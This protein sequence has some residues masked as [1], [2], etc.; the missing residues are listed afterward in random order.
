MLTDAMIQEAGDRYRREYDRYTKLAEFV[1][2][3]CQ[4]IVFRKLTIRASVQ[5][6]AKNPD[7][8]VEKLKK[9]ERRG[10]YGSVDEV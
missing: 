8:L 3:K 1:Y 10:K 6:R 2:E 7:S 9:P 5:R 4:E